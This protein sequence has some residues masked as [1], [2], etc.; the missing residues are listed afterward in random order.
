MFKPLIRCDEYV[1]PAAGQL[2]KLTVLLAVPILVTDRRDV[3]ALERILKAT[4]Q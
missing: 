3:V 2:E 4:R 1:K